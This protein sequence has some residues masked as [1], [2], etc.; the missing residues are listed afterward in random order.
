MKP[1]VFVLI[2]IIIFLTGCFN[3]VKIG[4]IQQHP[5]DYVGKEVTVEGEVSD[6]FS[7]MFINY[8]ELK[9]DTGAIY[10]ITAKPLPSKGE[11]LKIKAVVQYF[12]LGDKQV[13]S[14]KETE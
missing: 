1:K 14:L 5:R 2:V 7:L 13:I 11:K 6:I 12:A 9:D 4:D 3:K 8:F 10:V